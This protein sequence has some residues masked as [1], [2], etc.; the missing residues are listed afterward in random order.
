MKYKLSIITIN[1]NNKKG[2]EQTFN[3]VFHQT[4]QDFEY[5]VID[6]GSTDGSKELIEQYQDQI[7]YW[8][9]EK[10]GGIYNAMNKGILK[11]TGEYLQFLNSGDYLISNTVFEKM[12]VDLQPCDMAYGNC[13]LVFPDG[14]KRKENPSEC[15]I[16][17]ET[18]FRATISHQSA[19]IHRRMFDKYGLYD[20]QLK[21]ASDWK[22]FFIAFGL[23]PSNTIYKNI[24]MVYFSMDGLSNLH[25][26][27]W[28][29]EKQELLKILVPE[30]I[31][32]EYKKNQVDVVM[33]RLIRKHSLTKIIYRIFQIVVIRVSRILYWIKR[34]NF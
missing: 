18:F 32:D 9:S 24:D 8:V 23:N 13:I 28:Y 3:S 7:D 1:Y 19:F 20:E 15:G 12:L 27:I 16:N 25:P 17:F 33:M 30:T 29:N 11:S 5:I 26:D 22:F 4:F 2:L 31:L 21:L 34:V 10:D 14:T 6:G